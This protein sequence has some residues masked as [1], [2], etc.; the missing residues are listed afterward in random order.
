MMNKP[1]L[2]VTTDWPQQIGRLI[3]MAEGP[4]RRN[5]IRNGD[6]MVAQRGTS[7]VG[8]TT[9][10]YT[11]DGWRAGAAG[12]STVTQE[13]FAVDQTGVPMNPVNYIRIIRT[14]AAG[15]ANDVLSHRIEFPARL[16][17]KTV[18]VSFWARV[19]SGTKALVFDIASSGTTTSV[20]TSDNS[21]TASTT[22]TLFSAQITIPALVGVTANAYL[23]LRIREAA[24]FG[25][26]TLDVADVQLEEGLEATRF[27]RLNYEDQL[28]WARRYLYGFIS[29]GTQSPIPGNG[30]GFSTTIASIHVPF[31]TRMRVKPTGIA[32]SSAGHFSAFDTVTA[33]AATGVSFN[34]GDTDSAVINLTV[35]SGLTQFRP[36][37]AYF[38]NA[39]GSLVFTGAEL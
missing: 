36:Y 7:F 39:S 24:S 8:I 37:T 23:A 32:I 15:A 14:V 20:D 25:T 34:Y 27:E 35:A 28:A 19:S 21:F 33:T 6:F 1:T 11:L 31:T 18:T 29:G 2:G 4:A 5:F 26:F 10:Q 30:S 3:D 17:G 9:E 13:A 38:N 16:T 22:W 12:T